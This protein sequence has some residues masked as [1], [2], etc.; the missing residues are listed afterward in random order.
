MVIRALPR[1]AFLM[2]AAS[3][4]GSVQGGGGAGALDASGDAPA[5]DTWAADTWAADASPDDGAQP[6]SSGPVFGGDHEAPPLDAMTFDAHVYDDA[7]PPTCADVGKYPSVASC[8]DDN[9]CAGACW[10]GSDAGHFCICASQIGG[11]TWPLVCCLDPPGCV[12]ASACTK[13]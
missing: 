11:C 9:Y 12:G 4:G 7:G 8:C 2:L 10:A 6:D 1:A 13:W 3:C 5:A